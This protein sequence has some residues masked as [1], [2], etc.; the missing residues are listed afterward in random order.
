VS[1]TSLLAAV[2][3]TPGTSIGVALVLFHILLALFAPLLIP[4]GE[5]A[6][7]GPVLL[8]PGSGDFVLGTDGIGRD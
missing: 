2:R 7:A 1:D 3:H 6:L 5:N 8:P 4:Y